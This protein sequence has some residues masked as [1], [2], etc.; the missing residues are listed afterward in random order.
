MPQ[1]VQAVNSY[2]KKFLT[3]LENVL[4]CAAV[5]MAFS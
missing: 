3:E 1:G 4:G 2:S 5:S